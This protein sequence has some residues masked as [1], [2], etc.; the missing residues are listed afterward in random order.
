M[1]DFP[2]VP[3]VAFHCILNLL[4]TDRKNPLSFLIIHPGDVA[5]VTIRHMLHTN[6][7][8]VEI[9]SSLSEQQQR[10]LVVN[11][12]LIKCFPFPPALF[13]LSKSQ[14]A[15]L[16]DKS[17]MSM[18]HLITILAWIAHLSLTKELKRQSKPPSDQHPPLVISLL[19]TVVLHNTCEHTSVPGLWD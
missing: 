19:T 10:L 2:S 3:S 9:A 8:V 15:V 17:A 7:Q 1:A 12:I 18:L 14:I 6:K 13:F 11:L 5:Y 4:H 16:M